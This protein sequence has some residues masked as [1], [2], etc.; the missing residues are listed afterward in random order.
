MT[1]EIQKKVI[2]RALFGFLFFGLLWGGSC[3]YSEWQQGKLA[4]TSPVERYAVEHPD[5]VIVGPKPHD[6]N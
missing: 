5:K 6:C 1:Y 2:K 4:Q 3:L